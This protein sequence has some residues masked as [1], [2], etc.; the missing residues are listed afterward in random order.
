[1]KTFDKYLKE[2]DGLPE[3]RT[4]K[5]VCEGYAQQYIDEIKLLKEELAS[6]TTERIIQQRRKIVSLE[7]E[8]VKAKE[9][10]NR[11]RGAF[12]K[13][14]YTE[15]TSLGDNL[16]KEI[17]EFLKSSKTV[18]PEQTKAPAWVKE[19]IEK[20]EEVM[21]VCQKR[22][23][24]LEGEQTKQPEESK[25]NPTEQDIAD[26]IMMAN[27]RLFSGGKYKMMDFILYSEFTIIRK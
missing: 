16:T 10:V 20:C 24:E 4:L 18:K 8:L 3:Y 2:L 15:R 1:M 22:I 27:H 7:S 11:L 12:N 14:G 5:Q 9:F 17:D 6:L 23:K 13:Y 21:D 25:E 19:H 26:F